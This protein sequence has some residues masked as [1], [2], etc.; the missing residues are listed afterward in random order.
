MSNDRRTILTPAAGTT[1]LATD[2]Q[3]LDETDLIVTLTR[4]SV[5]STLTLDVDYTISGIGAEGGAFVSLTAASLA[6]DSYTLDGDSEAERVSDYDPEQTPSGNQLDADLN[7]LIHLAQESKRDILDLKTTAGQA[8]Q[9]ELSV[10]GG[11]IAWRVVGT[12]TWNVLAGL[13]YPAHSHVIADVAGLQA[14]LDAKLLAASV[15]AAGLALVGA[16]SVSA[17]R[18]VL[19]VTQGIRGHSRNLKTA[20]GASNP[21][22]EVTATADELVVKNSAG[23]ARLLNAVN[24]TGSIA[25]SGVN[26]LDTGT[27]ASSTWYYVYVIYNN[28]AAALLFSTSPTAPTL[29][30]G[31]SFYA[32]VGAI[33]NEASSNFRTTHSVGRKV[34]QTEVEMY[35]GAGV[36]STTL[37]SIANAVP[38]AA[39]MVRGRTYSTSANARG[40]IISSDSAEII[41]FTSN[42]TNGLNVGGASIW[43]SHYFE[44][45]LLTAQTLWR[46]NSGTQTDCAAG[47]VGFELPIGI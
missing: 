43:G 30:G 7:R 9:I 8:P 19:G 3:V 15:S 21:N 33:Y 37:T 18:A 10:Q 16:T 12:T 23:D 45:P 28:T 35:N 44:L 29:P 38:P 22:F 42:A 40:H 6:G 41:S 17:E 27:E 34:Y 25:V 1:G 14:T 39:N 4:A 31:Y 32:L 24:V 20:N 2:F 13:T 47:I 46:R 11:N 36:T 26:G 5:A